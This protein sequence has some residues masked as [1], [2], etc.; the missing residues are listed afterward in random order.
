MMHGTTGEP[1]AATPYTPADGTMCPFMRAVGD[2]A[3]I[4]RFRAIGRWCDGHFGRI[5]VTVRGSAVRRM[6]TART[7]RQLD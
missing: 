6:V 3:H 2:P 1:D 7:T 5:F 4:R